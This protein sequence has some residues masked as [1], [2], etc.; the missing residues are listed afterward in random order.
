MGIVGEIKM[1]CWLIWVRE[2]AKQPDRN[3]FRECF[4]K[5]FWVVY[6]YSNTRAAVTYFFMVKKYFCAGFF[7]RWE[8]PILSLMCWLRKMHS[9]ID[10]SWTS[11]TVDF[12][13]KKV[14]FEMW[15]IEFLKLWSLMVGTI[16]MIKLC[17][18]LI[19]VRERVKWL[20]GKNRME[21]GSGDVL[22]W[23]FE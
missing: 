6:A 22:I 5:S 11:V 7:S 8:L 2:S 17:S 4:Y 1:W 21:I 23:V 19:W 14:W 20:I 18:K 13:Q 15:W 10:R 16:W 9:E 3:R 12:Y